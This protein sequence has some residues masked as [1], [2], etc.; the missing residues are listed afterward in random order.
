MK[1][2]RW[3]KEQLIELLNTSPRFKHHLNKEG[4][5]LYRMLKKQISGKISTWDIQMQ[6]NVAKHNLK[7]VYPIVSKSK[8]IGFDEQSTNTFGIDYLKTPQDDGTQHSFN[9][10][11]AD[12]R[13]PFIQKQIQKPYGLKALAARKVINSAIKAY[14][15]IQHSIK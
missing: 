4:L 1:N 6:V 8:N 12:V 3:Q 13:A 2:I 14:G 9:F 15:N 7:V 10:S 5:D 11:P